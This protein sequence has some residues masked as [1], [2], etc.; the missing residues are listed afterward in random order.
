MDCVVVSGAAESR[1]VLIENA[2]DFDGR[3][4]FRRFHLLFGGEKQ[5][6]R[7]MD[8]MVFYKIDGSFDAWCDWFGNRSHAL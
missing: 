3:P 7:S 8:K 2:E 4:E 6:C 1:E 5:N